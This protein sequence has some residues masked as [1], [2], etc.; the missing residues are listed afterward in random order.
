MIR[1]SVCCS[2]CMWYRIRFQ[3]GAV[4]TAPIDNFVLGRLGWGVCVF[5]VYAF[6]E[7]GDR[8]GWFRDA[9]DGDVHE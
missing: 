8:D 7:Y 2:T 6:F 4:I 5:R 1:I 3:D 9:G